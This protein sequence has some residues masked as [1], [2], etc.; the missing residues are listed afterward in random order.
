MTS[1]GEIP[2][3][4]VEVDLRSMEAEL[5][6]WSAKLDELRSKTRAAGSEARF[7]YRKRLDEMSAKYDA[8]E[9]KLGELKIAGSAEWESCRSGIEDAWS[10]LADAF[11]KLAN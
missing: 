11:R 2:M 10:Q 3:Q 9:E 5:M 7:D 1:E 8:A 4:T 6:R